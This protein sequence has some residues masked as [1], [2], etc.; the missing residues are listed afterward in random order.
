MAGRYFDDEP[1]AR[2][3]IMNNLRGNVQNI[4]QLMI[5]KKMQEKQRQQELQDAVKKVVLESQLKR[6]RLKPGANL[7]DVVSGQD[8]LNLSQFEP[9]NPLEALLGGGQPN[10]QAGDISGRLGQTG[11]P[12]TTPGF[13]LKGF[14]TDEEGNLK[15]NIESIQTEEEFQQDLT[16]KMKEEKQKEIIKGVSGEVGGRVAL[17]KESIK[18]IQDIKKILFPTGEVK[19]FKR[20]IAAG[21]NI[22]GATAP[23]I[24]ALIPEKMPF[25]RAMQDVYRKM[26]AAISGRQLIQTGVA[27]RP[28]ETAK[29][30]SQFAPN[31]FSN[32]EAALQGLNELEDFY[33]TYLRQTEPEQRFGRGIFTG[34]S[35]QSQQ[36]YQVG[37]QINKGGK[38]YQIVGFDTDGEPL[39]DLVR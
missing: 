25:N 10:T 27:A 3:D 16:R 8:G 12:T 23:L 39:V 7:E 13:R 4:G 11:Q 1:S 20:G 28:E 24:G 9:Y 22:P 33:N 2:V 37:Q 31:L 19:S 5:Q 32:P 14:T 34:Q 17:A 6:M 15:Y 26:G 21:S 18:N 35:M 30:I 38:T 36:Q 29:L